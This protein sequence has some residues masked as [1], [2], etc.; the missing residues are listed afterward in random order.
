MNILLVYSNI[1]VAK[2]TWFSFG[3][4]SIISVLKENGF[5]TK[6]LILFSEDDYTKILD[7]VEAFQPKIIGFS[8]VASQFRFVKKAVALV[9]EK[10]PD[11]I[12]VCGG[13]H[14]TLFP[15]CLMKRAS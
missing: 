9:R 8:T 5:N 14:P 3:L 7:E 13:V 1:N 6:L 4:A 15:E 11:K 2:D 10:Y 12:L